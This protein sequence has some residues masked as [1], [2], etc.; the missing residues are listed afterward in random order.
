MGSVLYFVSKDRPHTDALSLIKERGYIL[1][2]ADAEGGAPYIFPDPE[3]P[4]RK[5]GFEVDLAEPIAVELGVKAR[6]VQNAWDSLI[7]ALER[8]TQI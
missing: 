4:S 1:W 8:G 2:G 5:I 3:K 6:H 7:P